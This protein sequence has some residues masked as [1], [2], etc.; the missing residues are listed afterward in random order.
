MAAAAGGSQGYHKLDGYSPYPIEELAARLDQ[1]KDSPA[2]DCV[3]PAASSAGSIGY[4]LKYYI[5]GLG[6]PH[7][8][9]RPAA[10]SARRRY[11]TIAFELPCCS[12]ALSALLGQLGPGRDAH[13]VPSRVQ[14]AA[15]RHGLA[16]PLL[17]VH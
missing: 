14:C 16:Q 9:R 12:R 7:Q 17:P 3:W 4:P 6:L 2:D 8:Y 5:N 13:A 15:L 10:A 1:H 11:I